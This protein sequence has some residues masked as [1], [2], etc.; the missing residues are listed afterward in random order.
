MTTATAT[1]PASEKINEQFGAGWLAEAT[2]AGNMI[3]NV[4]LCG[5]T[6][7]N[8]RSYPESCFRGATV[9]E[10]RPVFLDHNAGDP[11]ARSVKDLAG[12]I[13]NAR[14][15]NA[16]PYGDIKL[17]ET[18]A[19]DLLQKI[20]KSAPGDCGMSHSANGTFTD[21]TRKIV[22]TIEEVYSVDVVA[23]PA[24]TR[25]FSE[26]TSSTDIQSITDVDEL[27]EMLATAIAE[28]DAM[29]LRLSDEVKTIDIYRE[30]RSGGLDVRDEH[31]MAQV[32]VDLLLSQPTA[33]KRKELISDRVNAFQEAARR[34]TGGATIFT[35]E[36]NY[37]PSSTSRPT[38]Q[39]NVDFLFGNS[40]AQADADRLFGP[41]PD[42]AG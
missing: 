21:S 28:R 32:F 2:V 38:T 40:A 37:S 13:V 9:Y 34:R 26:Q 33:E 1:A 15:Q 27:K 6:S 20:A 11:T 16:K 3:K 10:N 36:R 31:H 23:F 29:F 18:P 30:A 12:T 24:S 22:E 7:K 8:D 4:C 41:R 42:N 17:L 39:E 19:G 25:N 14:M 35:R 5:T